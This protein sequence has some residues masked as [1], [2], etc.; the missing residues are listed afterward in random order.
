LALQELTVFAM[1]IVF[2]NKIMWLEREHLVKVMVKFKSFC[3]LP[4]IHGTIDVTQIHVLKFQGQSIVNYISFKSKGYNMQLQVIG[5]Y[6]KKIGDIFVGMLRSMNNTQ[7]LQISNLY[8]R[9]M[10]GDLF[11]KN[12]GEKNI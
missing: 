7:I 2:K 11:Q 3:G 8:Q 12:R 9:A 1:N 5:D 4:S 6:H 10:H